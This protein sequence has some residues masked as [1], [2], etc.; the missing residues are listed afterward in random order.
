M[1]RW[2]QAV[3]VLVKTLIPKHLFCFY[4]DPRKSEVIGSVNTT[5]FSNARLFRLSRYPLFTAQTKFFSR[6]SPELDLMLHP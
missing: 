4:Y 5:F 1:L 6:L 2:P 3:A